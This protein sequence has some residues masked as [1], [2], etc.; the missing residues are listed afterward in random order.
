MC[1]NQHQILTVLIQPVK[2]HPGVKH[3]LLLRRYIPPRPVKGQLFPPKTVPDKMCSGNITV[4]RLDIPQEH[5]HTFIPVRLHSFRFFSNSIDNLS[6][7]I[8]RHIIKLKLPLTGIIIIIRHL[9]HPVIVLHHIV[10][11]LTHIR[12][13]LN[14]ITP[15]R[16]A[17]LLK[18][19]V[20]DHRRKKKHGN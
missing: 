10:Q 18:H 7:I 1:Q 4:H 2:P 20:Y 12:C 19:P 5:H 11:R 8:I 6:Q 9:R 16:I 17:I 15:Q 3:R 13:R 14:V